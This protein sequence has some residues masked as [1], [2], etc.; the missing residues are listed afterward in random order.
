MHIYFKNGDFQKDSL[1]SR[2]LTKA[3]LKTLEGIYSQVMMFLESSYLRG[4]PREGPERR[5]EVES[6]VYIQLDGGVVH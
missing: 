6:Q 4:S 1:N 5:C 2:K 3:D